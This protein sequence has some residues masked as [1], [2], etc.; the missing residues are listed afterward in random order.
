M[1]E[2]EERKDNLFSSVSSLYR[3]HAALNLRAKCRPGVMG[4]VFTC[5][6]GL[7]SSLSLSHT[8]VL[9]HRYTLKKEFANPHAFWPQTSTNYVLPKMKYLLAENYSISRG[10]FTFLMNLSTSMISLCGLL[11]LSISF[12]S[13]VIRKCWD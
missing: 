8:H 12:S 5:L 7:T 3:C 4:M 1:K 10:Y 2:G 9:I 6:F 13:N 11:F